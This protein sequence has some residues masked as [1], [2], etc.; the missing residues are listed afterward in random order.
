M[1]KTLKDSSKPWTAL[2]LGQVYYKLL[3]K[4]NF[5]QTFKKKVKQGTLQGKEQAKIVDVKKRN[6]K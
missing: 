5:S 1:S 6:S 3:H 4:W 2:K